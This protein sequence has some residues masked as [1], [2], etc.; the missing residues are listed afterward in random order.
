M[1]K[2]AK[3]LLVFS[4]FNFSFFFFS[5]CHCK[6]SAA[7]DSP[8]AEKLTPSQLEAIQEQQKNY[9]AQGYER[10]RVIN[11]EVDG[12]TYLI[13]LGDGKKIEPTNLG[14]DFKKDKLDVWIKY[15]PKKG[16]VSTCM[17]G[18]VVEISDIQLRK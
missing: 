3:L 14:S 7:T 2:I 16:G 13:Q 6:K 9:L 18:Q 8:S 5:S 17:A 10:A 1:K 12:C 15:V 11:Y 4:F